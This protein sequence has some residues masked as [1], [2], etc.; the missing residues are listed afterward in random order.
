MTSTFAALIARRYT[1][2]AYC[3]TC[4]RGRQLDLA[5]LVERCGADAI[6]MGSADWGPA[7]VGGRALVCTDEACRSRNTSLRLSPDGLPSGVLSR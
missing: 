1:V 4:R 7:T 3:E 2:T 6:I 5:A